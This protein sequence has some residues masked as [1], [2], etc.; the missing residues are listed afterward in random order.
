MPEH[1]TRSS[2][3]AAVSFIEHIAGLPIK[4]GPHIADLCGCPIHQ[5][6]QFLKGTWVDPR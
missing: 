5:A 3:E 6:E 2:L 1:P 4:D